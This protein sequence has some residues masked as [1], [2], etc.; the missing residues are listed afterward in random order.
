MSITNGIVSSTIIDKRNNFNFEIINF[1]YLDADVPRSSFDV[2]I[3]SQLIPIARIC[4]N[5]SD[6][7][8]R[9]H[10]MT[11]QLLKEGL[12]MP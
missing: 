6:F 9:G 7:N 5:A 1:A 8:N 2:I 3:I 10:F 4:Y 12:S 11:A